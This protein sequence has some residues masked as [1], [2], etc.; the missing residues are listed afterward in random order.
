MVFDRDSN[1]LLLVEC[2]SSDVKI[3]QKV[4]D[5]I[6]IYNKSINSN[7]MM[8]TNGLDH[9]YFEIDYTKMNYKFLNKFP[10]K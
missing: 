8:V 1:V 10:L 6:V 7:Y 9:Y 5:Q 4:F 2:K 3:D